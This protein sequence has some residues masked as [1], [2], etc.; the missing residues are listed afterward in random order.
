MLTVFA[1]CSALSAPTGMQPI[2]PGG[3]VYLAQ[4]DTAPAVAVPAETPTEEDV[5][6]LTK[7]LIQA[8]QDKDWRLA[9]AFAIMLLVALG[10]YAVLKLGILPDDTR[11]KVLPWAAVATGT[12]VPFASSLIAGKGWVF[13]ALAALSGFSVGLTAIGG[14]ELILKPIVEWFKNRSAKKPQP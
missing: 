9:V 12:L 6:G 1:L 2:V 7:L 3:P 14:W 11:K 5:A 10:N 8:I 4:A 13:A